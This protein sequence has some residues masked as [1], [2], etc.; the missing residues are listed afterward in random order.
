MDGEGEKRRGNEE[1]EGPGEK[2]PRQDITAT[3][4]HRT[5]HNAVLRGKQKLHIPLAPE[6]YN[7]M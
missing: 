1:D 4:K 6:E 3:V 2:I 7:P 5:N